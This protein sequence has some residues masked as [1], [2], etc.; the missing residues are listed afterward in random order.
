[1]STQTCPK[2]MVC[3][4][5]GD[6]E[7]EEINIYKLLNAGDCVDC[8]LLMV[9]PSKMK[10]TLISLEFFNFGLQLIISVQMILY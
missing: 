1:M 2:G 8:K 6:I 9:E 4:N 3:D 10:N 7:R 5:G